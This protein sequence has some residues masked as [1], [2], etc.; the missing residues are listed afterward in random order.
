MR[1]VA[2][3]LLLI[4]AGSAAWAQADSAKEEKAV[5]AEAKGT[6]VSFK[7]D[8]MP[9]FR[10]HCLP[11][12]AEEENNPSEL[13]LDSHALLMKGGESG[14]SVVPGKTGES[15]LVQKL[16]EKPPFGAR[17]PLNSKKKIRDGKAVWLSDDEAKTIATWVNQGAK[18][19]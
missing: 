2:T 9:V 7:E 11:C 15:V 16:A 17:M 8:V 18:N 12:H 10:K 1:S 6:V 14:V 19:N 5:K 13:S 4:A 3:V